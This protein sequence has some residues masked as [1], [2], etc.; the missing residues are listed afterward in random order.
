LRALLP[1][2][3][4][5]GA[6]VV[7]KPSEWTSHD[8]VNKMR[9]FVGTKKVGH[10]GTLDPAATGVLPLIIGRATRLAQFYMRN[11]KT[12]E[13]VVR[14]GFSTD[15]YDAEGVATSPVQ[16]VA[17]SAEELEPLLDRFRG[18]IE[19]VPPAISAKK[20]GG[21]PAYKLARKNQPVE[22]AAVRV[23][24]YALDLL[25]VDGA[26][27]RLRV[28]CSSGTYIRSIAHEL[29][30]VLGC[31]AHL[32]S[33]RRTQ[34]GSFQIADA[35][36]LPTIE[37]LSREGRVGEVLIPTARLLPDMPAEAVDELTATQIR[38]GRDFR[39]SSADEPRYVK[40]IDADGALLA[41]GELR[42][43]QLYHPVLVY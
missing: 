13:G 6:I 35:H 29:G 2:M 34:S 31:G 16:A 20:I 1:W 43:P 12:Y 23:E 15:S 17:V 5:D 11:D 26:E 25:A 32:C 8:V 21:R 7:D 30:A 14:F 36:T 42:L 22:L 24:I 40:A 38:N 37:A 9:R 33:L 10:L 39:T 41:I 27:A 28:H 19:Q 3:L 4:V 18:P